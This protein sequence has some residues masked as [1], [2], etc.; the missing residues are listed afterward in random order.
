MM[1]DLFKKYNLWVVFWSFLIFFV[2]IG[3]YLYIANYNTQV[4]DPG[5]NPPV[6]VKP[7]PE[8]ERKFKNFTQDVIESNKISF[9]N[10][11]NKASV[12]ENLSIFPEVKAEYIWEDDKTLTIEVDSKELENDTDFVVN[13]NSEAKDNTWKTL[14]KS[15]IQKFKVSWIAKID[16][17]TPE[18]EI[19]DL[20]KN[21]TVRFSKPVSS[22][23]TLDNQID[24][25]IE[26]T[27]VL[28]G[29]CIW[30][31]S[32][33]FQFRP[34]SGFPI[35]AKYSVKVPAWVKTIAWDKTV[36]G[37]TFEITTPKFKTL[38]TP[39]SWF[40]DKPLIISFNADIDLNNFTEN[41]EIS[42]YKNNDLLI[43]YFE[44][45]S[46]IEWEKIIKK[47]IISIYPK[48]WDWGYG[49]Y[50]TY[51]LFWW[52]KSLRWNISIG[53]NL[54][55]S[56]HIKE[57]VTDY[58]SFIYKDEKLKNKELISNLRYAENEAIVRK[59]NPKIILEFYEEID[60]N[61]SL[62]ELKDNYVRNIDFDLKYVKKYEK[63]EK[64]KK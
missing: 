25:P 19:T 55:N 33:T 63:T 8:I 17:V 53:T 52:L 49:K 36:S 9:S 35:W 60:L 23:T 13:V 48:N 47:N 64:K 41:F 3:F 44:V 37:K 40:K 45:D 46:D 12:L 1:K 32:S 24:C 2:W 42:N 28:E 43:K 39:N 16:F 50:Y 58:S 29:K 14:E 38:T 11:M 57:L 20:T 4:I 30:I 18:W 54:S 62:F 51:K 5:V 26:I 10:P 21:I 6:G 34:E 56:F 7:D 27:P 59:I 31:T 15:I 61:K 22:L